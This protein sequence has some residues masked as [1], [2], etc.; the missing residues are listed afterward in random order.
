M[1]EIR[2]MPEGKMGNGDNCD[3]W[4]EAGMLTEHSSQ[5]TVDLGKNDR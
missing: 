5:A 4:K 1:T 2:S 3:Y